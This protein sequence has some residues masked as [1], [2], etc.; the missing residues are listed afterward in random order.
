MNKNVVKKGKWEEWELEYLR[1][2]YGKITSNEIAKKINR[3]KSAV[4]LKANRS[5]LEV[6]DKYFYNQDFFETINNEHKAYWLGFIMAD[7]SVNYNRDNRNYEMSIKLKKSDDEHLK[8]FN[9]SINGNV[10]VTYIKRLGVFSD[11]RYNNKKY[12]ECCQ[13]RLYSQKIVSDLISLGIYQNKTQKET[14]LPNLSDELL[15]QFIRGF[16]DG[17]GHISVPKDNNKYGYRIGFTNNCESFLFA[18]KD[19]FNKYGI[20]S[21]INSDKNTYK[22]EMR[23]KKSI[24]KFLKH[25]YDNPTIYLDRKYTSYIKLK[26][27]LSEVETFQ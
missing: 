21:H 17:D 6:E 5:G 25:C 19:F 26:S 23:N 16:L 8:K 10:P 24:L 3:T 1:D 13:I 14:H 22:L 4:Q 2:N 27:L 18:L 7:G 12:Y 15:W 9:K 20:V 11:Y